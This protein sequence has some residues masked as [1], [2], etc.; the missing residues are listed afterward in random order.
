MYKNS[1]QFKHMVSEGK[2]IHER[3]QHYGKA[4]IAG[5]TVGVVAIVAPEILAPAGYLAMRNPEK[6]ITGIDMIN[7][8]FNPSL[9]PETPIGQL[10]FMCDHQ[11]SESH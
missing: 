2:K 3:M 6:V 11:D 8:I 1:S 4:M 9:P 5:G 10:W 7:D